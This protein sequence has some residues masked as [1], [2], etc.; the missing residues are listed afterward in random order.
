MQLGFARAGGGPVPARVVRQPATSRKDIAL[1]D[2]SLLQQRIDLACAL[3]WAARLGLH[4]GVCNHFSLAV[5][6]EDGKVRGDRFLI[7]PYGWHW[8]EITASSLVLCDAESNVVE[9]TNAVEPTAF[10]IHSRIHLKAPQAVCVLHTHM[11]YATALTLRQD[12]RLAM[13]EQ[14]ALLF[15]GRLAYDDEYGGLALDGSEG[16]RIAARLGNASVVMLASHGVIVTGRTVAQAFND[17][18]YLERAAQAQV[19]AASGGHAL[20]TIPEE[21][22]RRAA[23]QHMQ[24]YDGLSERLFGA[25]RRLLDKEEPEYRS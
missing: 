19:L 3:R 11:P 14:N 13:C 23:Q 16:D 4:E 18:Y 17:L 21:V 20:R 8:S 9:G 5:A 25:Y 15:Y 6:D 10:F 1:T 24:E 22:Q 12:G 7:N 2:G